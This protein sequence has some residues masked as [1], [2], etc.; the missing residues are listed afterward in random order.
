MI[1]RKLYAKVEELYAKNVDATGLAV[2][3]ISYGIILLF[4]I[5]FLFYFRHLMYDKVPYLVPGELDMTPALIL[6]M[7][8][9][10]ALIFGAATRLATLINYILTVILIGTTA[11]FEYHMFYAYLCINTLL[12]FMPVSTNMSIDRLFKKLKYSNTKFRYQPPKTVSVLNYVIPVLF[13]IG[14]VY[15]DS[16]F[17]KLTSDFWLRGLGVWL[18]SS[19]PQTV[20]F[21][22][23]LLLNQKWLVIGFGYLILLFEAAFIFIFWRKK[24]RLVCLTIGLVLHLGILISYPIPFFALGISAIYLLLVPIGFWKIIFTPKPRPDHQKRLIFFYDAECPLCTRTRIILEHLDTKNK[25]AFKTVQEGILIDSRIAEVPI[26]RL[27]DD[28]HSVDYRNVMYR[29]IDTYIQVF[30]AIWYLKPL[31]WLIRIPGIYHISKKVYSY[32]ATNRTTERCTEDNCGYVVPQLPAK[33]NDMKILTN[34]TIANLKVFSITV[35]LVAACL[36]Q[37]IAIYN[38]PSINYL[39]YQV[40][41]DNSYISITSKIANKVRTVTKVWFGITHHGVFMDSHFYDYNHSVAVV[42]INDGKEVW[43]PFTDPDGTPGDYLFGNIWV[44]YTFRVNSPNVDQ[45][46]LEAGVRDF[47]AF[48]AYKNGISL[49]DAVFEVR[50]KRNDRPINW[51]KDFL[52]K[53]LDNEWINAGVVV[54]KD[55]RFF[56]KIR[57]IESL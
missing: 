43:L 31:S 54:W 30:S 13:G 33:D 22:T 53:Q 7:L 2:F 47:T 5:V 21:D 37:L 17:F 41:G 8:S 28:I 14:F 18:P 36:F 12:I 45:N 42:Y 27:L 49:E 10:L 4:E 50:A 32:I 24:W 44:K 56:P 9:V 29:G 52:R 25:I 11:S 55:K 6:W 40:A 15:F 51:S 20:L 35:G 39:K 38:S 48:W 34:Y 23:S 19:M 3:R 26:E 1:F 57:E 46:Q 16:M